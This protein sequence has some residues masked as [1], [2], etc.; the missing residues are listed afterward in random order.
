MRE[1]VDVAVVGGGPVGLTAAIAAARHGLSTTVLEQRDLPLDKACGEGVMPGGVELLSTLGVHLPPAA[2]VPLRGVRFF[3]AGERAEGL[4]PKCGLGVRRPVLVRALFEGAAAAGVDLVYGTQCV[5]WE[6][7]DDG[8]ALHTAKG[9]LLA[10]WL[11]AADGLHSRIRRRIGVA[12]PSRGPRRYGLRRHYRIAPWSPFVEVHWSE[13]AEAYVTPV[14]PDEVGVAILWSGRTI[15]FD[16]VLAALPALAPRLQGATPSSDLRGAGPF[17]QSVKRRFAGRVALVGDA[18]GYIDPLT[19]EGITLG[20][21]TACALV[22]ILA[23]GL[24]L[25]R[26]ERAYRRLVR[27]HRVLTE[28]LLALRSRPALRQ[29]LISGLRR[30]PR[31]FDRLLALNAAPL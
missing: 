6:R 11:I 14:G 1:I 15:D 5:D 29:R 12:K 24:P 10:R 16:E 18:A 13:D 19:G 20:M 21:R 30:H 4:L 8:M 23:R 28:L 26:Y 22:E 3:D 9:R 31:L 17:R 25:L 2:G 7:R 27:N